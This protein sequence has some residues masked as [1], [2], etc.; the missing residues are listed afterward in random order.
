VDDWVF[1]KVQPY[2]QKI[3]DDRECHKLTF[4]FFGPFHVEDKIG[5]VAYK[6]CL[7][8]K[9]LI[10]PV[11]HVLL[12][13]QASASSSPDQV[14][15]PPPSGMLARPSRSLFFSAV[16]TCVARRCVHKCWSNRHICLRQ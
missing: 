9:M 4:P 2:I 11:V 5:E 14:R 13:W 6:L 10:H 15:L 3:V 7:P 1:L 8:S 12:L 16:S